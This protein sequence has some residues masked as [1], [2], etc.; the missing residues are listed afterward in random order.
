MRR[1]KKLIAM[2]LAFVTCFVVF[3]MP[4]SAAPASKTFHIRLSSDYSDTNVTITMTPSNSDGT[5]GTIKFNNGVSFCN[6]VDPNCYIQ[7]GTTYKYT[8]TKMKDGS[9]IKITYK[10]GG[11]KDYLELG[12]MAIM[13][14][15]IHIDGKPVY[16]IERRQRTVL[17]PWEDCYVQRQN[18]RYFQA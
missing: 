5:T 1:T 15:K 2:M 8:I 16:C 6:S 14:G 4:V 7:Q 13:Y 12:G 10:S 18:N 11:D 3:A 9:Q 17:S